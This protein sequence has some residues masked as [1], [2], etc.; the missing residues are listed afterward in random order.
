VLCTIGLWSYSLYLLHYLIILIIPPIG[1]YL[2]SLIIWL[3]VSLLVS[4]LA[5]R[6]IEMPGQRLGT[7]LHNRTVERQ[8]DN[9]AVPAR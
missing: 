8:T 1:G 4:W 3:T 5:Y 7:W 6:L 2:P 9:T